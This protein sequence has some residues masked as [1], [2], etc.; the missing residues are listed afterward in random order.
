MGVVT[1]VMFGAPRWIPFLV[2]VACY[3]AFAAGLIAHH[4]NHCPTFRHRR[5]ND[6]LSL[7]LSYFQGYPAFGWIPIHN[8]NHHHFVNREGDVTITWRHSRRHTWWTASLALFTLELGEPTQAFVR[9]ARESHPALYRRIRAQY[10]AWLGT[11]LLLLGGA[12]ALYGPWDGARVWLLAAV[13]PALVGQWA[14]AFFSYIQH[15]HADPWSEHDHSRN[16]T[17][18]LFNFLVFNTGFHTVHHEHPGA[19]W[20]TLPELHAR[21]QRHIHPEL[22]QDNILTWCMSSY[23]LALFSPRFGTRQIGR[24]AYEPPTPT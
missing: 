20:S 22:E 2:P 1:L 4:H 17:G 16:F 11:H 8:L 7:W 9:K 14:L 18:K 19:H 6:A 13:L 12:L 21:I 24:A 3:L 23:V 15:V 5:L 10:A